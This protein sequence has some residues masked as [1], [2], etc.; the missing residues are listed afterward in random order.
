[1]RTGDRITKDRQDEPATIG[2]EPIRPRRSRNRLQ[3]A[4]FTKPE[5]RNAYP[6]IL[7]RERSLFGHDI[8]M[9]DTKPPLRKPVSLNEPRRSELLVARCD[10]DVQLIAHVSRCWG[11]HTSRR[12]VMARQGDGLEYAG[13]F[14]PATIAHH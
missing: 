9:L 4:Y 14:I 10:H 11:E 2:R 5:R 8:V 7:W 1:M 12:L 13:R 6:Y 3:V